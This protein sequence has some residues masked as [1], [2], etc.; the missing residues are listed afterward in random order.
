MTDK[1]H[2]LAADARSLHPDALERLRRQAVA[3]VESG[4]PQLH[5]A[6]M[7]GISRKA[8]GSWVRA[9]QAG[10]EETFRPRKR[11]R[12]PGEQLALSAGQQAWVLKTVTG[13]PPDEVGLPHRLWTRRA[14]A[15]LV[16]GQ[17]G[18]TLSSPTIGH[19]LARWGLVTEPNLLAGLRRSRL[20]QLPGGR[21]P[22]TRRG[23]VRGEVLWFAWRD[24]VSRTDSEDRHV[25]L[26]VTNRGVLLFL[27]DRSPF[28]LAMLADFHRRLREQ[29]RRPVRVVVCDWPV[30]RFPLLAAWL[31]SEPEVV[32]RTAD[33]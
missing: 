31:G 24:G 17:F 7:L 13:S 28:D 8:V 6:R 19:Y 25:L 26:A 33:P 9:Y 22:A 32:V 30:E 5:V 23:P 1:S 12:R 29:L 18:V 15:E 16:S 14:I 3:A 27:A 11:G 2:T 10:G 21:L 20:S 4:V